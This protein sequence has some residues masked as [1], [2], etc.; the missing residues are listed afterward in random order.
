MRGSLSARPTPQSRGQNSTQ[1]ATS[2]NSSKEMIGTASTISPS[3]TREGRLATLACEG[4]KNAAKSNLART[5]VKETLIKGFAFDCDPGGKDDRGLR[6]RRKKQA[7]RGSS[8]ERVVS[9]GMEPI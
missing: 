8:G 7:A 4:N 5:I 6:W 2:Q 9:L 3:K 1:A